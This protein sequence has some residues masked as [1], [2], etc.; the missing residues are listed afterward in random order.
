M[1]AD[2]GGWCIFH[3]HQLG[4]ADVGDLWMSTPVEVIEAIPV[5][6]ASRGRA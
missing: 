4:R 6:L 3:A 1:A 2:L 5:S